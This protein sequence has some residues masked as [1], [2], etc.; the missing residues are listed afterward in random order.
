M[1]RSKYRN[2]KK[3]IN[4]IKFDSKKEAQRYLIL[5]ANEIN[6]HISNLELQPE[7]ILQDKFK[8]LGKTIRAIKYKADFKYIENGIEI[9]EDVKGMKTSVYKLKKKLLLYKYPDI[10]FIET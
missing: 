9:V 1:T 4:G 3:I 7:F 2:V 6:G 10:N 5:Q 8:Y